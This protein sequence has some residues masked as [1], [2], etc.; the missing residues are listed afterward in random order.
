MC[1][2]LTSHVT[3]ARVTP[4]ATLETTNWARARL[5]LLIGVSVMRFSESYRWSTDGQ[6]AWSLRWCGASG[7]HSV[8]TN[9]QRATRK[10]LT[11]HWAEGACETMMR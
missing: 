1:K 10:F 11:R 5:R 9:R 7:P 4:A 6:P 8:A 2:W 3:S